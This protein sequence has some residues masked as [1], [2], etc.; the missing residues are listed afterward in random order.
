MYPSRAVIAIALIA[1]ILLLLLVHVLAHTVQSPGFTF[2]NK[3]YAFTYIATTPAEW[4]S[5][6]MNKTVG[7]NTFE[8]FVFPKPS[9]YPFWMKNTYYPLDMIWINGS[10]V[11]YVAHAIPCIS[12]SITQSNCTIYNLKYVADYVIEARSG[13]TN[14]TGL[15]V[16]S[17]VH[18]IT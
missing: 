10:K 6:L 17:T 18:I 5:G 12:Y 3:T 8:I 15:V 16:G 7:N 2:N 9:I 11:V 1:I 13:F 4:D 14:S